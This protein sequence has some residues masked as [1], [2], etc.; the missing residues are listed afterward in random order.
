[1]S[2]SGPY[3]YD[4]GDLDW[5]ERFTLRPVPPGEIRRRLDG[6]RVLAT[7]DIP[8]YLAKKLVVDAETGVALYRLVQLF[9]TPNVPGLEAGADQPGR[10]RTTWQYLFDV[11]F[12]PPDA[13]P[14][15]FYLSVYDLGTDV[16]TGLSAF[17]DVDREPDR[18]VAEPSRDP[19]DA[20][21][22]P[23][24]GFLEGVVQ[25]VLN[26]VDEPVPATYKELWV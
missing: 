14:Y 25:L 18:P 20:V 12:D 7:M 26:T 1:M 4:P 16:S 10:H 24:D 15:E 6:G 23:D 21:A 3:G 11:T 8:G 17:L 9:G 2:G 19:L 13:E 5:F 22:I